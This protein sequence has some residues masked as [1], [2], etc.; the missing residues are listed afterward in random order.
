MLRLSIVED[1]TDIRETLRRALDRQ[2]GITCVS[3]Y[4]SAEAALAGLPGDRPELV[5]MDIGLPNMSGTECLIRLQEKGL[6]ADF[7]MF[8]VFES[9]F[10]LFG[11]L[12]AGAIGYVLKREGSGGVIKAVQD[13]QLGG[14]PMSRVIARR[15]LQSFEKPTVADSAVEGLTAQ[16]LRVLELLTEGLLNKEIGARLHISEQTVKQHNVAI[17]RK[18]NV[19]NRTEAV[20]RYLTKSTR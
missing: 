7:L 17:Y 2:P 5:L 10:H 19:H 6:G 13:Y 18:L 14:A 3:T 12:E 1:R 20:R 4:A 8:T 16:Q 9:D 15:V 11:A